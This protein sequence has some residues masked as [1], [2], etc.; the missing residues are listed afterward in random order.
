M[1]LNQDSPYLSLRTRQYQEKR[2]L[3]DEIRRKWVADT[4]EER[5]RQELMRRLTG[6]LGYPAMQI[7]IERRAQRSEGRRNSIQ[8][9]LRPAPSGNPMGRYDALLF[10][11]EGR[12]ILL[13]ECKAPGMALD[14]AVFDQVAV[15]NQS[16]NAPFLLLSNGPDFLMAQ[17]DHTQGRYVFASEIPSYAELLALM[18]AER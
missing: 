6:Q 8:R 18:D 13:I 17:I 12:P 1:N 7:S 15:Y 14:Q 5:V 10:N 16:L 11:A 4:P 3:F 2:Q 9:L